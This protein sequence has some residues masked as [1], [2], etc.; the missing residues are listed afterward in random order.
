MAY[1]KR[2]PILI[3]C[4]CELCG[5]PFEKLDC[6]NRKYCCARCAMIAHQ[7]KKKAAYKLRK[8][9]VQRE[10]TDTTKLIIVMSREKGQSCKDIAKDMSW[11]EYEVK[12][13]EAEIKA[14]G[15]Y[16]QILGRMN[17]KSEKYHD[18]TM[19]ARCIDSHVR[20]ESSKFG[21]IRL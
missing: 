9:S 16:Q 10:I 8:A 5:E 13:L 21:L 7:N 12:K 2:I 4:Y 11:N 1:Q 6:T 15:E 14:S 20:L 19:T 18:C 3:K 17:M